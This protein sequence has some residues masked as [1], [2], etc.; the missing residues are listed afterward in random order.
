[1]IFKR[2]WHHIFCAIIIGLT[3]A[4]CSEDFF[5]QTIELEGDW[6]G[7]EMIVHARLNAQDDTLGIQLQKSQPIFDESSSHSRNTDHLVGAEVILK[8]DDGTEYEFYF[9]SLHMRGLNYFTPAQPALKGG[10]SYTLHI[11][12]PDFESVKVKE[13]MPAAPE[14]ISYNWTKDYRFEPIDSI[15]YTQLELRY[16][17][18]R[19]ERFMSH[20]F[21][22][23]YMD[24][25]NTRY[26]SFDL[27]SR[28]FELGSFEFGYEVFESVSLSGNTAVA[29][30]EVPTSIIESLVESRPGV[31]LIV[32]SNA[33]TEPDF[34][35]HRSV[36]QHYEFGDSPFAEPVIVYSNIEYANGLYSLLNTVEIKIDFPD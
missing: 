13:T 28:E 33:I 1:M 18:N 20:L 17:N 30:F 11:E 2:Y 4:A 22:F 12:H 9:D 32:Y 35:F 8:G 29:Y 27:E 34:L 5:T 25:G 26:G 23:T 36:Q 19:E 6:D 7:P 21:E 24:N 16:A 31:Q 10:V 14:L 15:Y 3:A